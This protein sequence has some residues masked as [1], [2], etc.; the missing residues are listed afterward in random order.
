MG[1]QARDWPAV[2]EVA[3]MPCPH[4]YP[5]LLG[6]T[7]GLIHASAPRGRTVVAQRERRLRD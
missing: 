6:P 5:K 4:S 1:S 7:P 2:P 3:A